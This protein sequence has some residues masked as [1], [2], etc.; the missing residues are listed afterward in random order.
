MEN[1]QKIKEAIE[2]IVRHG[3]IDGSHH[4]DW[5]MDQVVRKLAGDCY[6]KLVADECAGE[7]GPDTYSWECGIAP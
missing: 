1:E 4:K 5:V 3:W 7:D 6:D 2:L